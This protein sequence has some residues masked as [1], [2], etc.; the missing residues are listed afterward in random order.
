MSGL[1][2]PHNSKYLFSTV[3]TKQCVHKKRDNQHS[4]VLNLWLHRLD[5]NCEIQVRLKQEK[6]VNR[7]IKLSKPADTL[8]QQCPEDPLLIK[9]ILYPTHYDLTQISKTY[10]I[11][12]DS[13]STAK[14][15]LS[16]QRGSAKSSGETEDAHCKFK[17]H[18]A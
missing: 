8:C 13:M 7:G 16:S 4:Q 14:L 3:K 12:I 10:I 11:S 15:G 6:C 17:G 5:K 9:L 18:P 2:Y 1:D